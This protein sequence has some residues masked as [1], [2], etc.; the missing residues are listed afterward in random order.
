MIK[1]KLSEKLPCK[2]SVKL[3]GRWE[4]VGEAFRKVLAVAFGEAPG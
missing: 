3:S 1:T 4:A 2:V